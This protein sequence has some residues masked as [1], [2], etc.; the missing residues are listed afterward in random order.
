MTSLISGGVQKAKKIYSNIFIIKNNLW[1]NYD[2]L[3]ITTSINKA[4]DNTNSPLTIHHDQIAVNVKSNTLLWLPQ[5]T[6]E[7]NFERI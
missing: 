4:I 7:P 1:Q 6:S 5:N 2:C 3:A